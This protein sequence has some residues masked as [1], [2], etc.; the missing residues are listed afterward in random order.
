MALATV[1]GLA[2]VA[3]SAAEPPEYARRQLE[4]R[5]ARQEI[6]PTP[7]PE[8]PLSVDDLEAMALSGN[9]SLA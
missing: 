5:V 3:I 4:V 8:R 2:C 1:S 6:V 7:A 9:P